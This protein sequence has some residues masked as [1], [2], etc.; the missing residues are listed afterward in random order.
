[1]KRRGAGIDCDSMPPQRV[2]A[3]LLLECRDFRTGSKPGGVQT[4]ENLPFLLFANLR[5]AEDQELVCG[6]NRM[7]DVEL[8]FRHVIS[9]SGRRVD[10]SF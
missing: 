3:K 9:L 2:I 8:Q 7:R 5:R 1:M 4:V 10:Q 6:A